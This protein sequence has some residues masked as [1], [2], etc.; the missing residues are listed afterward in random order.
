MADDR[1]ISELPAAST[2][3][4]AADQVP[5][6]QDGATVRATIDQLTAAVRAWVI[7]NLGSGPAGA[8]GLSVLSGVGAPG[9]E[10]GRDGEFWIDTDTY[11]AYGP[12]ASGTWPAP[13]RLIGA[14]GDPGAPGVD[15][16]DGI[17][18]ADGAPGDPGAQGDPGTPGV[19][20]VDGVDGAPGADGDI[21][22]TGDQGDPGPQGDPGVDGVDGAPGDPGD[23]GAVGD[24]GPQGDPGSAGD[25]GPP[26]DPGADGAPGLDGIDGAAGAGLV[27]TQVIDLPGTS[28]TDWSYGNG[29]GITL[30]GPDSCFSASDTSTI[31]FRYDAANL[32]SVNYIEAEFRFDAFSGGGTQG[33]IG[34]GPRAGTGAGT[35]YCQLATAAGDGTSAILGVNVFFVAAVGAESI[36][37]LTT[38]T[39]YTI[40]LLT[41]GGSHQ[42]FLNGVPGPVGTGPSN[43]ADRL[44]LIQYSCRCSW[45]NIKAWNLDLPLPV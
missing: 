17:D 20:G 41:F 42:A 8:D 34:I 18:G 37:T 19:D 44:A 22:L 1:R 11:D 24:P 23:P 35:P 3:D 43:E 36:A 13:V 33:G 25:P 30:N 26:G 38:G 21:G 10:D 39:W 5:L 16:I 29:S 32:S 4:D 15:G 31:T 45:R 28:L 14:D 12:K 40:G 7:D 9:A 2:V 27:W 6:V